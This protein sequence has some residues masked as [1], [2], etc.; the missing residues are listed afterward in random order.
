MF[1]VILL[2]K[3]VV[4]IIWDLLMRLPVSEK[5]KMSLYEINNSWENLLGLRS[6]QQYRLLYC[7]QIIEDFLF[8]KEPEKQR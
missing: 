8:E 4:N 5:T 2:I 3:L 6:M 7:L 1:L